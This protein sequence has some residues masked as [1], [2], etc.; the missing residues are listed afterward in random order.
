MTLDLSL[1]ARVHKGGWTLAP[2]VRPQPR[3]RVF[4]KL[5]GLKAHGSTL[6]NP[7]WT[8]ILWCLSGDTGELGSDR[9]EDGCTTQG[10]C[11][12]LPDNLKSWPRP[13]NSHPFRD[14]AVR[15][16]WIFCV[17]SF[18]LQP[19]SDLDSGSGDPA[20]GWNQ[21]VGPCG[22][23]S[24]DPGRPELTVSLK[25]SGITALGSKKRLVLWRPGTLAGNLGIEARS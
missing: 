3:F 8:E 4:V 15:A 23:S 21:V 14:P 24:G 9:Q 2:E 10:N 19:G 18:T 25:P 20:G 12:H 5:E 11:I 13:P 17:P 6:G 7:R 1:S 16:T 22:Y